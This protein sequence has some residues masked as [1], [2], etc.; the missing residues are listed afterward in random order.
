MPCQR[1]YGID[2]L[3]PPILTGDY[4]QCVADGQGY[5]L[6]H[7]KDLIHRSGSRKSC[8]RV[9]PQHNIINHVDRIGYQILH[10]HDDQHLKKCLIEVFILYKKQVIS[11]PY[12]QIS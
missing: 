10:S 3:F 12:G 5:L 9:T 7:K 2:P 4:D 8:L 11:P 6:H 1:T